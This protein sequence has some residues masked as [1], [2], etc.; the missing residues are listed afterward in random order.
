[1][2]CS[3]RTGEFTFQRATFSSSS[4][5]LSQPAEPRSNPRRRFRPRLPGHLTFVPAP[6]LAQPYSCP[7][8]VLYLTVSTQRH[9]QG[10][11]HNPPSSLLS[12]IQH[13]TLKVRSLRLT[14]AS[15][16][17]RRLQTVARCLGFGA[18]GVSD[19]NNCASP[20]LHRSYLTTSRK[21]KQI[22]PYSSLRSL[23]QKSL[24][25]AFAAL[26]HFVSY[27]AISSELSQRR[28]LAKRHST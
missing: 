27:R 20:I 4:N 22:L 9:S 21:A 2:H 7:S 12:T 19:F 28:L 25:P 1:M 8:E 11:F 14:F 6:G 16:G 23:P 10:S 24:Y 17:R 15:A 18:F 3:E 26:L 5:E 13:I